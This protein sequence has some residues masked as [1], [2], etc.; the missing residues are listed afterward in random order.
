MKTRIEELVEGFKEKF[1]LYELRYV[2]HGK[3]SIER[4]MGT[5]IIQDW[6]RTALTEAHQAGIDE[7]V[8]VV[9]SLKVEEKHNELCD[10]YC[11]EW[12]FPWP[13][14]RERNRTLDDTIKALQ[15]KNTPK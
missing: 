8:E 10:G 3:E 5:K 15:D 1:G 13:N 12:S 2:E 11:E 14:S 6:L 7:A 4:I 9:K